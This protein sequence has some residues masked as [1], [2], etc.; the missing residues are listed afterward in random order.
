M[1]TSSTTAQ[2]SLGDALAISIMREKKFDKLDFKKFHP[3]GNLAKKLKTASDIMLI[4]N[5]IPFVNENVTMKYAL[6]K[7]NLKKQG[8]LV[9]TN[10]HG[11]TV[12]VFTDGDLK[13]LMQKKNIINNLKIKNFITKNPFSV[14]V[15]SLATDILK[16]MNKRK[17]TNVCVYDGKNKRKTIGIIH[18]HNLINLIK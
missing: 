10:N 6:R 15:N 5:K 11:L 17:I 8:F 9:V 18:I 7:L 16:Q 1:P 12:G 4:G 13:R 2:L 14:R 3:E